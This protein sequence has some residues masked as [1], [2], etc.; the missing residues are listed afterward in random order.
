MLLVTLISGVSMTIDNPLW[1]FSLSIY[2]QDGVESACVEL[3]DRLGLDVNIV[4]A[5]CWAG[6]AGELLGDGFFEQLIGDPQMKLWRDTVIQPLRQLRRQLKQHPAGEVQSLRQQVLQAEISAE[7]VYQDKLWLGLQSAPSRAL[8]GPICLYRN[9]AAYW[10]GLDLGAP[11]WEDVQP[12][13]TAAFPGEELSR[14]A[15]ELRRG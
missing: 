4:L 2:Q 13:L 14:L 6:Q 1:E 9:L 7:R 5:C 15:S 11:V 12:L 10:Q 8:T 3:Q